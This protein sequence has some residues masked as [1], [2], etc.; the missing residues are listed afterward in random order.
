MKRREPAGPCSVFA[1]PMRLSVYGP[2]QLV[3]FRA[4]LG[5]EALPLRLTS[6]G[7]LSRA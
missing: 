7:P 3:G 4:L 6:A 1:T 2:V 5:D